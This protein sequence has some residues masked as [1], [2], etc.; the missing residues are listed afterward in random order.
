MP[1]PP[2]PPSKRCR[3]RSPVSVIERGD[4]NEY[5]AGCIFDQLPL[6]C[7]IHIIAFLGAHD[8]AR[9]DC[10]ARLFH[11]SCLGQPCSLVEE[12]LRKRAADIGRFVPSILP[13]GEASWVQKL[14]WDERQETRRSGQAGCARLAAGDFHTVALDEGG[15]LVTSS[16]ADPRQAYS[17]VLP[18]ACRRIVSVAAGADHTLA[19]T[20]HG[21]VLSWG[22][23]EHGQL[24]RA[25]VSDERWDGG[26]VLVSAQYPGAV[27]AGSEL[28]GVFVTSI[29]AGGE[30]SM[31]LGSDGQAYTWGSGHEGCLGHGDTADRW[32]P[33]RVRMGEERVHMCGAA[34]GQGHALFRDRSGSVY[35]CG[36]AGWIRRL[37]GHGDRRPQLRPKRIESLRGAN[38]VSVAAGGAFSL[39]LSGDG[40]LYSWGCGSSGQLGHGDTSSRLV[41]TP[42]EA[43]GAHR[44]RCM[45][46]GER[47]AFALASPEGEPNRSTL[48]SWGDA[49][50]GQLGHPRQPA[51]VSPP[52]A[53]AATAA[54]PSSLLAPTRLGDEFGGAPV[55]GLAAG[56]A[57]SVVMAADG[58]VFGFGLGFGC[59][60]MRR[61]N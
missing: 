31:A 34:A 28:D 1:A 10:T 4:A 9:I 6:E 57:H 27:G 15:Q 13:P 46:A 55:S 14:L 41:P 61:S 56:A 21:R 23:N 3:T 50:C 17:F 54:S 37:L 35:S 19:L 25:V 8:L 26:C 39:A 53:G 49:S 12:A 36:G 30:V 5:A 7:S 24:G 20:E 16:L 51:S 40:V 22:C 44:V 48:F 33:T 45:A 43:L 59:S 47:Y 29:A 58:Q 42:V 38:M 52:G 11:F 18:P 2:S 32:Q 60:M